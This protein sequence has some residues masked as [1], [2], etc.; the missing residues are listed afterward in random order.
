MLG[1]VAMAGVSLPLISDQVGLGRDGTSRKGFVNDFLNTH[2][3]TD[4]YIYTQTPMSRKT[5]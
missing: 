2:T 4:I 1:I 5:N 3:Y